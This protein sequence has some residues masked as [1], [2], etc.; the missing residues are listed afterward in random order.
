MHVSF[1]PLLSQER[2]GEAPT[3]KGAEKEEEA[4][5]E[6]EEGAVSAAIFLGVENFANRRD[7]LGQDFL[8]V[9]ATTVNRVS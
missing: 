4:A 1:A 6:A 9:L 3:A 8:T 2:R 5:E 7:F